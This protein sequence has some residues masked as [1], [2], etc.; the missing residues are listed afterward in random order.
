VQ[1]LLEALAVLGD[2]DR[3]RRRA[4]DGHAVGFQRQRQLERRLATVLNDDAFRLLDGAISSTSSSVSGS[5]YRRSEV[6]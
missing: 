2:I 4:D 1:Q 5:K 6:S 3:F